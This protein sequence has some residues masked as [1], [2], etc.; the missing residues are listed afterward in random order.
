ME[1]S[2]TFEGSGGYSDYGQCP[3]WI[4]TTGVWIYANN[5]G[6]VATRLL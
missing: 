2:K 1:N 6:S 5:A 3:C 4:N